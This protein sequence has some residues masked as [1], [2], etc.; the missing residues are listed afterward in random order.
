M[1]SARRFSLSE[2][3]FD[4]HAVVVNDAVGTKT[5]A[6][7]HGPALLNLGCGT[8]GH[9]AFVNVD[10]IAA[11]GVVAHDIRRG[12]P[13]PDGTFDLVYHS[14]MLSMLRASEALT[15][16]RECRRVLKPGGIL[17]VVTEDLEQMCRIY[18]RKLEAVSRGD[19]ESADDHEWMI[20][21]LY[22]QATREFSGGEMARYLCRNPLPNEA[23]IY[24]RIGEQGRHLVSGARSRTRNGRQGSPA[25]RDYLTSLRARARKLILTALLGS[26]GVH[27]LEVGRF[28]LTS[29]QVSHRMY[30]R[31]SL[32][33]L[34][35]DAGF[36]RVSVAAATQSGYAL[37]ESVNLDI[38]AEGQ[39]ARPHALIMEGIRAS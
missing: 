16:M 29:G 20:V 1:V 9:S 28:R 30:D 21:E 3:P 7:G 14:T 5:P 13:F 34:F 39:A 22:D 33:R 2:S 4:T 36:S 23:F 27:A 15:F 18:L 11:P 26:S 6:P 37:W 19:R 32:E 10:L 35:V 12:V 38:T 25:G 8:E 17:R 31:Y 24:S